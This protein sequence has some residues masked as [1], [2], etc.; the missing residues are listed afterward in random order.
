MSAYRTSL[1][2]QRKKDFYAKYKKV[3]AVCRTNQNICL[4]HLN[5]DEPIGGEKDSSLL[6]LCERHHIEIHQYASAVAGEYDLEEATYIFVR[7]YGA[8]G[9]PLRRPRKRSQTKKMQKK[10]HHK[11]RKSKS[12]TN[13]Y[14]QRPKRLR[15]PA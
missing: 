11:R 9:D 3:C 13:T 4:H 8:G 12:R 7:I 10:T 14:A 1:W 6:P 5:Y 15:Q 2:K